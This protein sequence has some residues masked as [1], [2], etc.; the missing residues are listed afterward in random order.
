M[1]I[2]Q[3]DANLKL[4]RWLE[5]QTPVVVQ[6][7]FGG[8]AC[9]TRAKVGHALGDRLT[10]M[11]PGGHLLTPSLSSATFEDESVE[12]DSLT[13]AFSG[14]GSCLLQAREIADPDWPSQ[15]A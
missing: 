14:G 1:K 3:A 8:W 10:L 11:S 7:T 2:S 9:L 5:N 13:I 12:F 15:L 6:I 4:R